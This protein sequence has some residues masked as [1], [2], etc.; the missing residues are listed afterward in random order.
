MFFCKSWECPLCTG[1]LKAMHTGVWKL[2]KQIPRRACAFWAL[3]AKI[4]LSHCHRLYRYFWAR[5]CCGVVHLRMGII[6]CAQLHCRLHCN[7]G[8]MC[9]TVT[10]VRGWRTVPSIVIF[11]ICLRLNLNHSS[12]TRTVREKKN[13]CSHLYFNQTRLDNLLLPETAFTTIRWFK[14][15]KCRAFT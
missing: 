4:I 5:F 7:L 14:L 6:F 3:A 12:D 13:I 2:G 8:F 10:A 9:K 15:I 11:R 1:W